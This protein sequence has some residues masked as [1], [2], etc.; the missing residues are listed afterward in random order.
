MLTQPG[1][2]RE[3]RCLH[4]KARQQQQKN[5]SFQVMGQGGF[6]QLAVVPYQTSGDAHAG[7]I[8]G[9][10]GQQHKAEQQRHA[11][12]KHEQGVFDRRV[13]SVGT[14]APEAD[15][16]IERNQGQLPEQEEQHQV[17]GA[18]DAQGGA[19]QQQEQSEVEPRHVADAVPGDE[20][21]ADEQQHRQRWEQN[22]D[23][24]YAHQVLD[25]EGGDPPR[26]FHQLKPRLGGVESGQDR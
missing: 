10:E 25:V 2:Q 22:R 12:S 23:A 9:I 8:S 17:K 6:Q 11:A 14:D 4:R 18:E 16:K 15:Q 24:V 7:E 19:L 5:Q 21:D 3:Q 1:V 20:D 26:L 13:A